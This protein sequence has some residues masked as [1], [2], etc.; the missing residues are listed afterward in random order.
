MRTHFDDI[1]FDTRPQTELIDT[2]ET[3][4][5]TYCTLTCVRTINCKSVNFCNNRR[6]ELSSIDILDYYSKSENEVASYEQCKYIGLKKDSKPEC[7]E[8]GVEI[9]IQESFFPFFDQKFTNVVKTGKEFRQK[10]VS[11]V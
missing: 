4:T 10:A 2:F 1:R 7:S 11:E 9:D 6:C 5:V 3:L 8:N